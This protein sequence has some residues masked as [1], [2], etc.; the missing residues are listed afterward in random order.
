M[1]MPVITN[2][3]P[4]STSILLLLLFIPILC[5]SDDAGDTWTLS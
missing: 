5:E 4:F 2:A 1:F 3:I